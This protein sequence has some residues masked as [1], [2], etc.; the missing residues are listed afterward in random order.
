[1]CDLV[2]RMNYDDVWVLMRPINVFVCVRLITIMNDNRT[3]QIMVS[4]GE[5]LVTQNTWEGDVCVGARLSGERKYTKSIL[6]DKLSKQA[7]VLR[8]HVAMW[9]N[10][11][12]IDHPRLRACRYWFCI[13]VT[14]S[15]TADCDI[16]GN[17][18][19]APQHYT[20]QTADCTMPQIM[21]QTV[22]V[23]AI[24]DWPH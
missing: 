9:R 5:G 1:M 3:F 23:Q 6:A 20:E 16:K 15:R 24:I 17:S 2:T 10:T 22:T 4:V 12:S 19:N 18:N 11:K 13:V 7:F 21:R 14:T 8:F